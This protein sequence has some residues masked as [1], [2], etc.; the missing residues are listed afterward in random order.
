MQ[1][2]IYF[3]MEATPTVISPEQQ[4]VPNKFLDTQIQKL[5]KFNKENGIRQPES[6]EPAQNSLAD[7]AKELANKKEQVPPNKD[8]AKKE[9]PKEEELKKPELRRVDLDKNKTEKKE[10]VDADTKEHLDWLNKS[11][12]EI[13]LDSNKKE[14]PNYKEEVEKYKGEVNKY[15]SR[16][17]ELEGILNDDY[18]KAIVEFRKNGGTDLN[19]LNK[20]LGI[21]DTTKLDIKDFY[22][23]QA[24]ALGLQG[25]DLEDAVLE[26][27]EKYKGLTK[28]EQGQKLNEYKNTLIKQSEEK[29]KSFSTNNQAYRQEQEK[30]QKSAFAEIEKEVGE[31][32][33]KKWRGLLIDAKMGKAIQEAAPLYAP[34]IKDE[35]G[36]IIG[37]D[38]KQ[39]VRMAILDKFEK[40]LYK[41]QYDLA[42]VS[43]YDKLINE[44][45]RPNENMTTNQVVAEAPNDINKAT[46]EWRKERT[47]NK[48]LLNRKRAG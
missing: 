12:E 27:M 44:R 40:Q 28:I 24:K 38:V 34:E 42:H 41:T 25:E 7:A 47:G 11:E 46:Q 2:Q 21:T 3:S 10:E 26:S 13:I 6:K 36:H 30:V 32:V 15:K 9:E 31:K 48:G 8:E 33:G 37:Y 19:E 18:V 39:G 14:E 20:H 45:N 4:Q 29:V 35:K 5:E 43:A 16:A 17:D 22:T 23:D 1:K